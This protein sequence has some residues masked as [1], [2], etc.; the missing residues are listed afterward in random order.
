MWWN[1]AKEKV[2]ACA[3]DLA[4]YG[5]R[6]QAE[7]IRAAVQKFEVLRIEFRDTDVSS[8]LAAEITGLSTEHLERLV[9]EGRLEDRRDCARGKHSFR[10]GNLMDHLDC[11]WPASRELP[12]RHHPTETPN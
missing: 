10:L 8:S 11:N 3:D 6:Q 1:Y 5:A 2:L 12:A 7:A 9:R 4:Q